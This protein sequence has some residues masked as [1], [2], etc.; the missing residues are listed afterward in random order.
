MIS[1]GK[2]DRSIVIFWFFS[3]FKNLFKK[4][5]LSIQRKRKSDRMGA[6]ASLLVSDDNAAST[7]S[8]N[9]SLPQLQIPV[10]IIDDDSTCVNENVRKKENFNPIKIEYIDEIWFTN[11]PPATLI[12]IE[13][14][15]SHASTVTPKISFILNKIALSLGIKLDNGIES[16]KYQKL[17]F[18][19][20]ILQIITE[21]VSQ[22]DTPRNPE[23]IT[24]TDKMLNSLE[25]YFNIL[26][27]P[28]TDP[29]SKRALLLKVFKIFSSEFSKNDSALVKFLS[30][31]RIK[32][33]KFA[34]HELNYVVCL[35]YQKMQTGIQIAPLVHIL[36]KGKL[37]PASNRGILKLIQKKASGKGKLLTS[38]VLSLVKEYGLKNEPHEKLKVSS[39]SLVSGTTLLC[40]LKI[41]SGDDGSECTYSPVEERA[42]LKEIVMI[43]EPSLPFNSKK[44][45]QY[46]CTCGIYLIFKSAI[47]CGILQWSALSKEYLPDNN[48]LQSVSFSDISLQWS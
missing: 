18:I 22:C 20:K 43:I 15:P 40:L 13:N 48:V 34:A 44:F 35:E 46:I 32:E 16:T 12:M 1:D 14:L 37:D 6:G 8:N 23:L 24:D 11:I 30:N 4:K 47:R 26:S 42:V 36:N 7:T 21:K 9:V 17:S 33:L 38:P 29:A 27:S 3:L 25:T 28:N 19:P 45:I 10:K 41:I 39:L 2:E 31:T 5:D